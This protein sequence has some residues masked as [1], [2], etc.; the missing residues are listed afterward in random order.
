MERNHSPPTP[1]TSRT[2]GGAT[3][4]RNA[5]ASL[6]YPGPLGLLASKRKEQINPGWILV[7]GGPPQLYTNALAFNAPCSAGV[8]LGMSGTVSFEGPPRTE[9]VLEAVGARDCDVGTEEAR[10][11]E[12]TVCI[13]S[14]NQ[15]SGDNED[16]SISISIPLNLV[17]SE[18][19]REPKAHMSALPATDGS[20]KFLTA[21]KTDES[22]PSL[23]EKT[24]QWN[25]KSNPALLELLFAIAS[26]PLRRPARWFSVSK[27]TSNRK[28]GDEAI[29]S[30]SMLEI[31]SF[32]SLY[33]SDPPPFE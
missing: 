25:R 16:A 32:A 1:M 8:S 10:C 2:P 27:W 28:K 31:E 19:V 24:G 23:R 30:S 22:T 14:L 15:A 5:L 12:H 4:Q 21:T 3:N 29:Q 17:A 11:H 33:T 6:R 9:P 26:P 7:K 18:D 20:E 13:D